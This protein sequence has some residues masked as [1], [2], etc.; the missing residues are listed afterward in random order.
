M[1]LKFQ[2][3]RVHYSS[4]RISTLTR[5]C[6]RTAYCVSDLVEA[7]ITLWFPVVVVMVFVVSML[8]RAVVIGDQAIVKWIH[9]SVLCRRSEG[10]SHYSRSISGLFY[11]TFLY[12]RGCFGHSSYKNHPD[13]KP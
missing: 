6:M 11:Y 12:G 7:R 9:V 10:R 5:W 13:A 8:S 4:R 2:K 3:S 1:Y